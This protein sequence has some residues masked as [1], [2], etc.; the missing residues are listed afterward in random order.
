MLK[1]G[2]TRVE[3]VRTETAPLDISK[4]TGATGMAIVSMVTLGVNASKKAAYGCS[5]IQA[6]LGLEGGRC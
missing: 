6:K 3:H 5:K 4:L 1:A 2:Q